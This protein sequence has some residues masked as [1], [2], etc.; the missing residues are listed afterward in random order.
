MDSIVIAH[1]TS[2]YSQQIK[3]FRLSNTVL[4]QHVYMYLERRTQQFV[5]HAESWNFLSL[6]STEPPCHAVYTSTAGAQ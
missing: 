3:L 1:V 2:L 6:Y 5:E 4:A